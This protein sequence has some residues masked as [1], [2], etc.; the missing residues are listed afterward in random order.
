[1]PH[2]RHPSEFPFAALASPNL[3]VL[4]AIR[5]VQAAPLQHCRE[6][7]AFPW[8]KDGAD[9]PAA[10]A[11][12]HSPLP[13]SRRTAR[14]TSRNWW[15]SAE[16]VC[17][18]AN[19]EDE[20]QTKLVATPAP[21]YAATA[22]GVAKELTTCV[23]SFHLSSSTLSKDS[24]ALSKARAERT[25]RAR[26]RSGGTLESRR[27][28]QRTHVGFV[29]RWEAKNWSAVQFLWCP[30]MPAGTGP[31]VVVVLVIS[32]ENEATR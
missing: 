3:R 6:R 21:D 15:R 24:A 20:Q 29:E 4:Q 31:D 16:L 8:L 1:M 23:F 5:I 18:H 13:P 27:H 25:L 32:L 22:G 28:S 9:F 2:P 30:N 19:R 7:K 12:C 17:R 26:T 10:S 11:A 14:N